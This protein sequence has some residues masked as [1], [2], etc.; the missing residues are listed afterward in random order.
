M[1]STA[2]QNLHD[3]HS[4]LQVLTFWVKPSG[5]YSSGVFILDDG[6][7]HVLP[8]FPLQQKPSA[9][10]V[11]QVYKEVQRDIRRL[12]SVAIP[13]ASDG[14]S[15]LLHCLRHFRWQVREAVRDAI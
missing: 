15:P 10:L 6:E 4:M 7:V 2:Q 1:P 8:C 9:T 11:M 12:S 3:V 13:G 14:I 5:P